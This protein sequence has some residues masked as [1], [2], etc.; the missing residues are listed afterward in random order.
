[1][2]AKSRT[3]GRAAEQE[4]VNLVKKFNLVAKRTWEN[5]QSTDPSKRACD[6]EIEL[7]PFQ[8][9]RIAKLPSLLKGGELE[10]VVGTFMREDNGKWLVLLNA[11][12]FLS[13]WAVNARLLHEKGQMK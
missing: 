6:V 9:K 1:M 12:Q 2:G 10:H 7:M 4:L 8:V 11:K 3:K 13:M 5:A